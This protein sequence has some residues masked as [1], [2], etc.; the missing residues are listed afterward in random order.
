MFH[1]RGWVS[2]LAVKVR[3]GTE[4]V[5]TVRDRATLRGFSGCTETRHHAAMCE[6]RQQETDRES[7]LETAATVVANG[8]NSFVCDDGHMMDPKHAAGFFPSL[9]SWV[10]LVEL[11][12]RSTPAHV[13][14]ISPAELSLA[15]S[16][17][18]RAA[19]PP[20]SVFSWGQEPTPD[21]RD[22][23]LPHISRTG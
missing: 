16:G 20:T 12:S 9:V 22:N 14:D 13:C 18:R 6:I 3:T 1:A 8:G 10:L 11:T 17:G 7:R 23:T 4:V 15:P 2:N 19:F 21:T 5:G